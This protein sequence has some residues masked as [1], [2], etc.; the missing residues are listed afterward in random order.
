MGFSSSADSATE[1][2]PHW[3]IIAYIYISAT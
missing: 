1:A 3:R 2:S